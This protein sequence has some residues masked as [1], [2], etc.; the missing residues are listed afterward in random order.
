MTTVKVPMRVIAEPRRKNGFGKTGC[1]TN[2]SKEEIVARLGMK[3]NILNNRW[4]DDR[5]VKNEW[6]FRV[7]G[8]LFSIWDWYPEKGNTS[9][10]TNGDPD[11]LEAIF[12]SNYRQGLR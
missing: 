11:V 2:L 10:S 7:G 12:G 9:W 4:S 5:K 6:S 8:M 3:P 1:L